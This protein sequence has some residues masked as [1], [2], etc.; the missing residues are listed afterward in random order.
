MRAFRFLTLMVGLV[1]V[2]VPAQ[3]L[4]PEERQVQEVRGRISTL[5]EGLRATEDI[6]APLDPIQLRI[7]AE[8]DG[9]IRT[10]LNPAQA[11]SAEVEGRLRAI[12]ADHIPNPEYGDRALARVKDL[13]RGRSLVV[14]YTVMRP[15]HHDLATIRGYI[16]TQGRFELVAVTGADFTGY[17]M[18]KAEI[19]SPTDGELWLLAWGQR[20][21][22]NGPIIRFR[23]YSFDGAA[24]RT[25]W[26]PEDFYDARVTVTARGFLM[27]HRSPASAPYRTKD[28]FVVTPEG[29]IKARN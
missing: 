28:E 13:K 2:V 8:I 23:A 21:T 4:T 19:P 6:E 22:A 9:Y 18:F 20:H 17:N 26:S 10:A 3:Q 12:L 14:A 15:P 27:E 16:G 1:Q 11:T 7:R 25:V 24:F 29:P 5:S